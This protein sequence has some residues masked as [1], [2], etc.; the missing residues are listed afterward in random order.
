MKVFV[1]NLRHLFHRLFLL[2]ALLL[3]ATGRV[4]MDRVDG[5]CVVQCSV[6]TVW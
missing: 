4:G 3:D 6:A 5:S 1:V 2:V